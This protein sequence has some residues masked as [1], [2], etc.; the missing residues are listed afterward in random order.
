MKIVFS[1]KNVSRPSFLDLCNYAY[2]YGY[3]GFEI[4]DAAIERVNHYDS[5]LRNDR[6]A[7]AKRKLLNRSLT[8]S[9]LHYPYS[10]DSDE[11]TSDSIYK[12]IVMARSAGIE[13]VIVRIEK[14]TDKAVLS[15]KL[16]KA[17]KCA[18]KSD[19]RILLETVGYLANTE[20]VI[21]I[22][23]YF[24]SAAIYASWNIRGN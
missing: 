8:V 11:A 1:T 6:T 7:D 5:I 10:I 23:N 20:N 9:A 14:E 15:E 12:Y 24:S 18:E 4:Y 21:D 13:N 17:I 19:V 2:D 3:S 16:E 22:I